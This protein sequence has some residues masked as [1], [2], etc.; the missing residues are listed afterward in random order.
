MPIIYVHVHISSVKD[1]SVTERSK[2]N[3]TQCILI[4]KNTTACFALNAPQIFLQNNLKTI[5][6]NIPQVMK[7]YFR[8]ILWYFAEIPEKS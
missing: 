7:Y 4:S 8:D 2:C 5:S 3:S 6:N 1:F